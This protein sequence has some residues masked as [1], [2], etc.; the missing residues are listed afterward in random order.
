MAKT[1]LKCPKCDRTFGMAAHLARHLSAGHGRKKTVKK[2]VAKKRA[3][4]KR[5]RRRKAKAV[6]RP[7]GAA[8]RLGLRNMSLEQLTELITAAKAMK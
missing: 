1:K 4:A 3:G 5:V 2:K 8:A 6:G 7:K